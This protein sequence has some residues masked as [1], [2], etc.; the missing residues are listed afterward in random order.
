M[1]L[2]DRTTWRVATTIRD[3]LLDLQRERVGEIQPVT[4]RL[5]D[6]FHR[7]RQ[8]REQMLRARRRGFERAERKLHARLQR[9]LAE[10]SSEADTALRHVQ[11][12]QPQPVVT[13]RDMVGE[14]QQLADEFNEWTYDRHSRRLC[15]VTEPIQLGGIELGR[16]EIV[17]C[18]HDL[19][20]LDRRTCY[21]VIACDPN[22]A[23][24][25]P[26]VTHPHVSDQQLCEGEAHPAIRKA[27][28][29]G[30][31]CEFFLL[32]SS[33]LRQ[34]NDESPYVRLEEWHGEP[35]SD[36]GYRAPEEQIDCCEACSAVI[37]PECAGRCGD[38]EHPMCFR[39]LAACES[40]D[41]LFCPGC[42]ERCQG[43]QAATCHGCISNEA[44]CTD[45][46][47]QQEKESDHD[48][49]QQPS[50]GSQ[51]SGGKQPA[52]PAQTGAEAR[53]GGREHATDP[54][55]DGHAAAALHAYSLGQTAVAAGPR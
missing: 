8:W 35:C 25:S 29:S 50:D 43:C 16:F 31:V 42:I 7:F 24:G 3:R 28:S 55:R 15:V 23:A 45:C 36:C 17:L 33:V 27:L 22:P 10:V 53:A 41:E 26:G 44:L 47:L 6:S 52:A 19:P 13:A 34:Y 11:R 48:H 20:S 12:R 32:V 51:H 21:E 46:Q 4:S 30:R 14:L 38:C 54:Q 18:L 39:C 5:G 37:C 2:I 1:T 40:C 49:Q 9:L